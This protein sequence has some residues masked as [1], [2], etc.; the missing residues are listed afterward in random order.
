LFFSVRDCQPCRAFF[1]TWMHI[2]SSW[3]FVI[4]CG[5]ILQLGQEYRIIRKK[6]K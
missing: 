5:S 2:S 1:G 4:T 6:K 3:A